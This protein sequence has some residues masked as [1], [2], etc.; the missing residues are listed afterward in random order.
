MVTS[1]LRVLKQIWFKGKMFVFVNKSSKVK[2][3][4]QQQ[5]H[6]LGI[7]LVSENFKTCN[8]IKQLI[9]INL[10]ALSTWKIPKRKF[11]G[12]IKTHEL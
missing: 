9:I 8:W 7:T 12:V 6:E 1:I 10:P 3:Q 4:Q 5:Q 2:Q 11:Q